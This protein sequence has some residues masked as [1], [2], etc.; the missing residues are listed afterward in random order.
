MASN[1]YSLI[2]IVICDMILNTK[3]IY[4]ITK[5]RM[6]FGRWTFIEISSR[7]QGKFQQQINS[8]FKGF[9]QTS[10][11]NMISVFLNMYPF[12]IPILSG[13]IV[14][15]VVDMYFK[16]VRGYYEQMTAEGIKDSFKRSMDEAEKKVLKTT[17]WFQFIITIL[18]V[19]IDIL[20]RSNYKKRNI[21]TILFMVSL[22]YISMKDDK[23]L[24]KIQAVMFLTN[25]I[26]NMDYTWFLA[27]LLWFGTSESTIF[28]NI[29]NIP[30]IVMLNEHFFSSKTLRNLTI[31]DRSIHLNGYV[32][33]GRFKNIVLKNSIVLVKV[34]SEQ[35]NCKK[36]IMDKYIT[37]AKM[38]DQI[39]KTKNCR[40][41]KITEKIQ[42]KIRKRSD[43]IKIITHKQKD[44][45]KIIESEK[46]FNDEQ[47]LLNSRSLFYN[48]RVT[49]DLENKNV[50]NIPNL[51]KPVYI[52]DESKYLFKD[53]I[54]SNC[55]LNDTSAINIALGLRTRTQPTVKNAKDWL[56]LIEQEPDLLLK[57][58][59]DIAKS[60]EKNNIYSKSFSKLQQVITFNSIK[61]QVT[62]G[63]LSSKLFGVKRY[64]QLI[65]NLLVRFDLDLKLINSVEFITN[66][67]VKDEILRIKKIDIDRTINK[68]LFDYLQINSFNNNR[69]YNFPRIIIPAESYDRYFHNKSQSFFNNCLL[70]SRFVIAIKI[71]LKITSEWA[72]T[73]LNYRYKLSLDIKSFDGNQHRGFDFSAA[74]IRE[75]LR[76]NNFGDDFEHGLLTSMKLIITKDGDIY[77]LFGS[78]PSGDINTGSNNSL[79][80]LL[81]IYLACLIWRKNN[82]RKEDDLGLNLQGDN[83]ILA[84]NNLEEL[85]QI[86]HI[87]DNI[88]LPV[89]IEGICDME[90]DIIVNPPFLGSIGIMA[91]IDYMNVDNQRRVIRRII[92][93]RD[94]DRYFPKLYSFMVYMNKKK[95]YKLLCEKFN[96][97]ISTYPFDPVLRTL[98]DIHNIK[99]LNP[100]KHPY[101]DQ[102]YSGYATLKEMCDGDNKKLAKAIG[103]SGLINI[104]SWS[105][106]DEF[107]DLVY[108]K[109]KLKINKQY[110][111]YNYNFS[112]TNATLVTT[113]S[114][115]NCGILLN[116]MKNSRIFVKVTTRIDN[117]DN[118]DDLICVCK[119]ITKQFKMYGIIT[120]QMNFL[121]CNEQI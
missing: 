66:A 60:F 121:S 62:P 115:K 52:N 117:I 15:K 23:N 36:E 111:P 33:N 53:D 91:T 25:S 43:I 69:T 40:E 61:T 88:G 64:K 93:I 50:L 47:K 113:E 24:K 32:N 99:L 112:V 96:C 84:S 73:L 42:L 19:I 67:F 21:V 31:K 72:Q 35:V 100:I 30:L 120:G 79:R 103:R 70:L 6:D 110:K 46:I 105:F 27:S 3:V 9:S 118:E 7:L 56:K 4:L 41:V 94:M 90:K 114:C 48:G 82:N 38:C 86:V 108:S 75:S 16:L 106:D 92:P 39:I 76:I 65:M 49:V 2:T 18:T 54:R 63:V 83:A 11:I 87:L 45:K 28:N 85:K 77:D 116:K 26:I 29:V 107:I 44:I 68:D 14:S 98:C 78:Q 1:N 13:L 109:F 95:S 17:K 119:S 8:L 102:E 89:K 74:C 80:L 37:T 57:S 101:K 51:S 97:W 59:S 10:A 22:C 12:I 20:S 104:N 5:Y 55:I 81:L 71:G 58:I 34:L